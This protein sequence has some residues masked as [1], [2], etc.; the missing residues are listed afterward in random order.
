MLL[1]RLHDT[2]PMW[3]CFHSAAHRVQR[4]FHCFVPKN[5]KASSSREWS[6]M[7]SAPLWR[8][9]TTNDRL[10]STACLERQRGKCLSLVP[11][12]S[13]SDAGC[14]GSVPKLQRQGHAAGAAWRALDLRPTGDAQSDCSSFNP[15]LLPPLN[16]APA[17]RALPQ[18]L[19]T[20]RWE[21][22]V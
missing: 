13:L 7:K 9:L 20:S 18:L 12:Y 2:H 10:S 6:Q 8:K 1:R 14:V 15:F 17:T 16:V 4:L 5:R 21:K 11:S 22:L 3:G 19:I